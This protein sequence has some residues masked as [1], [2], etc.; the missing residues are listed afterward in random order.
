MSEPEPKTFFDVTT[1]EN[2][3]IAYIDG[4]ETFRLTFNLTFNPQ[5]YA[6]NFYK[7]LPFPAPDI[8]QAEIQSILKQT[9]AGRSEEENKKAHD[10][11]LHKAA[12]IAVVAEKGKHIAERLSENLDSV[13]MNVIE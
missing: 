1:S 10:E 8:L 6:D 13:L 5:I 12:L 9:S 3:V 11:A 4:I 2:T 7:S